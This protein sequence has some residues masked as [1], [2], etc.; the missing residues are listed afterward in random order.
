MQTLAEAGR[1]RKE[2]TRLRASSAEG[3]LRQIEVSN[4]DALTEVFAF[5]AADYR[6]AALFSDGIQSF[7]HSGR[8]EAVPLETV[9]PELVS[10]KNTRGAF[11][12]RRMKMFLKDC[13]RKGRRHAD[14]LSLAALHLGD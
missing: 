9:L 1:A 10:F 5:D 4:S 7:Q 6:F 12:G 13:S 11:V 14:D 8:A 3:S 2:V